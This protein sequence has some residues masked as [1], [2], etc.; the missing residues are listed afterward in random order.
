[1]KVAQYFASAEKELLINSYKN[2]IILQQLRGNQNI[3]K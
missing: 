3:L 1:M 2:D